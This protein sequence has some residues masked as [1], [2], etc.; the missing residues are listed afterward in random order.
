MSEDGML[1]QDFCNK[2]EEIGDEHKKECSG[3]VLVSS[4]GKYP[5]G[6][7]QLIGYGFKCTKCGWLK[8]G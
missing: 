1:M 8:E 7:L 3:E 4:E 5:E 2:M 6:T